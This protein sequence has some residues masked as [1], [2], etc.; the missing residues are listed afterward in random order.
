MLADTEA[1]AEA[2]GMGM[3]IAK[4]ASGS[5]RIPR[6]SRRGR[7]VK[8]GGLE[9]EVK[10]KGGE[11]RDEGKKEEGR[12]TGEVKT[13]RREENR[14]EKTL[15]MASRLEGRMRESELVEGRTE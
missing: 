15:A 2:V 10:R 11:E 4:S 5:P 14:A 1:E 8:R 12:I 9:G 7:R 3:A 13:D 6:S